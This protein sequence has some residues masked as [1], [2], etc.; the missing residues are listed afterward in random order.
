MERKKQQRENLGVL[1]VGG[2]GVSARCV[3]VPNLQEAR[4]ASV[5][6]WSLAQYEEAIFSEKDGAIHSQ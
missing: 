2:G 5:Q 3:W 4:R 6:E 1:E